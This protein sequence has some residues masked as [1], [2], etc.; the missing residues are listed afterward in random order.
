MYLHEQ[1]NKLIGK[2]DPPELQDDLR[3]EFA[4]N[5]LCYDCDKLK[6]MYR[7]GR[8]L[9][10]CI[11]MIMNMATGKNSSFY[12]T[13][14]KVDDRIND[15]LML[16]TEPTDIRPAR[17]ARNILNQKLLMDAEQA[18]ESLIFDKY[19]ELGNC[20]AVAKYYGIPKLH[21]YAVVNKTK[22]ELKQKIKQKI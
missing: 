22:K 13:Y 1:I 9:Y 20:V 4:V 6:D 15:Y 17:I 14:R 12:L 5:M 21:V 7:D 8:I 3:Q 11:R 18:H 10:F 16:P 19:V 2:L